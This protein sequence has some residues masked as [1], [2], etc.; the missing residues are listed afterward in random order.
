MWCK[1]AV[2]GSHA[3]LL[4]HGGEL[5]TWGSGAGARLGTGHGA[6]A[7]TPQRVHTLWAA[8]APAVKCSDTASAVIAQVLK[9]CGG[10]PR[11]G[12]MVL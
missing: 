9:R 11:A 4:T 8:A 10:F 1:V 5:Y 6:A 2:G 12:P 3:G 7:A